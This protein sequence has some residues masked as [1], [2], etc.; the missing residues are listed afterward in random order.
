[1]PSS[2]MTPQEEKQAIRDLDKNPYFNQLAQGIQGS[3]PTSVG[4]AAEMFIPGVSSFKEDLQIPQKYR[5]MGTPPGYG[6][7][8]HTFDQFT[9]EDWQRFGGDMTLHG[10]NAA[11]AATPFFH[12][13]PKVGAKTANV[14]AAV[15]ELMLNKEAPSLKSPTKE[16]PGTA[17]EFAESGEPAAAAQEP[18]LQAVA[19]EEPML[20]PLQYPN[21]CDEQEGEPTLRSRL[22]PSASTSASSV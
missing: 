8:H 12:G 22:H 20:E 5:D 14:D 6:P 18:G 7:Q 10:V 16:S 13:G 19:I 11:A 2:I 9:N 3:V 21:P 4:Q 15:R 17:F 1:M